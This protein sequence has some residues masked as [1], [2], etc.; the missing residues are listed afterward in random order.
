MSPGGSGGFLFNNYEGP[1]LITSNP[2]GARR[3]EGTVHCFLALGCIGNAG[4]G[5][6][7]KNAQINKIATVDYQ[8]LS[9]LTILY[10]STTII[11]TGE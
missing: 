1:F 6:I 10:T 3:A 2:T 8:Y 7:A 11:V 4:V 9:V 5:T